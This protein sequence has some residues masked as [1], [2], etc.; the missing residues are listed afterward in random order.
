MNG[1]TCFIVL[2][3]RE[4][5]GV[6]KKGVMRLKLHWSQVESVTAGTISRLAGKML[7]VHLDVLRALLEA[8][9]RLQ[10]VRLDLPAPGDSRRIGRVVDVLAPR[11]K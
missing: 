2:S 4:R 6:R 8:D 10:H 11:A 1:R 3:L 5:A 7:T 9:D